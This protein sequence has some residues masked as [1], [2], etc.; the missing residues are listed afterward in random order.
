M[1]AYSIPIMYPSPNTAAEVFI[2][3]TALYLLVKPLSAPIAPVEK[4]SAH[5]RMDGPTKSNSAA[6]IAE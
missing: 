6:V 2:V 4:F 3:N 5:A 1:D